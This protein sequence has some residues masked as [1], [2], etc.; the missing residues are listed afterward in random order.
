[1]RTGSSCC[2]NVN[3]LTKSIATSSNLDFIFIISNIDITVW[4]IQPNLLNSVC[5]YGIS[6]PRLIIM[7]EREHCPLRL[8]TRILQYLE[9]T[10]HY[11]AHMYENTLFWTGIIWCLARYGN[12]MRMALKHTSIGNPREL[13][14]M[15]PFNCLCTAISHA[16]A[17][18][19]N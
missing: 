6:H 8:H 18:T 1:M 10:K 17:Q 3:P 5:W 9:C 11:Q 2:A 7:K 12:I 14:V 4:T 19:S 16:R 15:E 13:R